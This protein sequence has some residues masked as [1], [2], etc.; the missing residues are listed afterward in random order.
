M[1]IRPYT[2]AD[3]PG[4]L[5]LCNLEGWEWLQADPARANKALTAP[6]VTTM[7]AV[8]GGALVGFAQLQSDGEVQAHLSQIAVEPAHRRKGVARELIVQALRAA[9][10][11]RIDLI[12]NEG[13]EDFY[14]ALPHFRREGFRLYPEYSGPDQYRPE[15]IWRSGRAAL[16]G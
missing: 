11:V 10:G 4:V 6:G 8:E 15:I 9:G 14:R 13:A 1:D 3:L 7:V 2:P 12:A 5:R 16:A